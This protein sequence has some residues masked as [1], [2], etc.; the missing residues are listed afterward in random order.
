MHVD[1]AVV[2]AGAGVERFGRLRKRCT[3]FVDLLDEALVAIKLR[4]GKF[5][6]R[7]GP[8]E[9]GFIDGGLLKI[10]LPREFRHHANAGF[11]LQFTDFRQNRAA[12]MRAGG[13][14]EITIRIDGPFE[15]ADRRW[16]GG[17]IRC[18]SRFRDGGHHELT[19]RPIGLG[20]GNELALGIEESGREFCFVARMGHPV[21]GDDL[22]DCRRSNQSR[23]FDG[24]SGNRIAFDLRIF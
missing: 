7:T 21:C 1:R 13:G 5:T 18:L 23:R 16:L 2:G 12:L 17:R 15:V 14:G 4:D 11:T 6:A 22:N 24:L 20:F 19:D 3:R 10:K 9:R 8:G